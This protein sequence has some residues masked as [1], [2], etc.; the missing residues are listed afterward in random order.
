MTRYTAHYG[1]W[2]NG[3]SVTI[4]DFGNHRLETYNRKEAFAKAKAVA[5]ETQSIVTVWSERPTGA[6]LRGDSQKVYPD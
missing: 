1:T 5:N 4:I 6:G 3:G 2:A